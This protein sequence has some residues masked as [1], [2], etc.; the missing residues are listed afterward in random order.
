MLQNVKVALGIQDGKAAL[1]VVQ[2]HVQRVDADLG[3]DGVAFLQNMG[4]YDFVTAEMQVNTVVNARQFEV[5]PGPVGFKKMNADATV[6]LY[7]LGAVIIHRVRVKE[8][9]SDKS[10]VLAEPLD[11]DAAG[12]VLCW[13]VKVQREAA[14]AVV[15]REGDVQYRR[16]GKHAALV[17]LRG[18]PQP[19]EVLLGNLREEGK[20][21]IHEPL[22]ALQCA[23]FVLA[24]Y[25][26]Q[27]Q[28]TTQIAKRLC[29]RAARGA[30]ASGGDIVKAELH[31]RI[32]SHRGWPSL[33]SGGG[34]GDEVDRQ[35][36]PVIGFS[37]LQ[38]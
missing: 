36:F 34:L 27:Q 3:T 18:A 24:R 29:G 37:S 8:L 9:R 19:P 16:V 7:L 28:V 35:P 5:P 23:V 25:A 11:F 4:L 17:A 38:K 6:I 26:F 12:P 21:A 22:L 14:A 13:A 31:A 15:L 10:S 2:R 1:F 32:G 20:A 30:V 33:K